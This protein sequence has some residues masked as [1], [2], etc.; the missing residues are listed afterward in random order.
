MTTTGRRPA[1]GR[2]AAIAAALVAAVGLVRAPAAF[3]ATPASWDG[4]AEWG[5]Y[6]Y[7]N[8]GD[9]YFGNDRLP[10]VR[11]AVLSK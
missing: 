6:I 4:T 9:M 1:R 2:L 11:Q 5:G 7:V 8:G 10:L 3:A